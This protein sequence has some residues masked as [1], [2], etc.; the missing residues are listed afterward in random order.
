[1]RYIR[2]IIP[3][4]LAGKTIHALLRSELHCSESLIKKLKRRSGAILL[5]EEPVRS[6]RNIAASG[7]ILAADVD[8]E[9]PIP[10]RMVCGVPILYEDE[11]L[12]VIH[13]P[14]GM[15]VH[16]AGMTAYAG[17]VAEA[18]CAYL[19]GRALHCVNRLDRGTSGVM[20]IAKSGYAHE[21][22]R[23]LLHTAACKREYRAIALGTVW[24]PAGLID[25]PIARERESAIRRCI[26]A[27]G[28]PSRTRYEVL[29]MG[30]GFSLLRI[31]PETG[32]TH[33]I[34]V[35][36]AAIGHP[37]VGD[38]LYGIED[39]EFISRPALHSYKICLT[40]PVSQVQLEITAPI[41]EDMTALIQRMR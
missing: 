27:T 39:P 25:L 40:S 24:P 32:R 14:A 15:A 23:C 29:A 2:K 16:P 10:D 5:N 37:L 22:M 1:M 17:T 34:R 31:V 41:P 12:L 33:Q 35:H 20:A 38:W 7:D 19:G 4:E 9:E 18:V 21:R 8:D 3:P 11:D 36:M 26:D 30:A 28:F 6:V 13:K